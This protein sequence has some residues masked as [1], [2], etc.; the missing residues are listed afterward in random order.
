MYMFEKCLRM[1]ERDK[2]WFKDFKDFPEGRLWSKIY[3]QVPNKVFISSIHRHSKS[4][5]STSFGRYAWFMCQIA[6]VG[7]VFTKQSA[8][9]FSISSASVMQVANGDPVKVSIEGISF[10]RFK[11]NA[12]TKSWHGTMRGW[13]YVSISYLC[14]RSKGYMPLSLYLAPVVLHLRFK[15]AIGEMRDGAKG[16][17][18]PSGGRS[19]IL[20]GRHLTS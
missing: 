19:P 5:L 7:Y 18:R 12:Q 6:T 2:L 17:W 20:A 8:L 16:F 15:V 14:A 1:I 13:G 10:R 9:I 3:L 11:A 4:T